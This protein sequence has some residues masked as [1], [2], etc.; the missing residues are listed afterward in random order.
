MLVTRTLNSHRSG[1]TPPTQLAET[2][3]PSA[4]QEPT[5]TVT[6][7]RSGSGEGWKMAGITTMLAAVPIG[8]VAKSA[9]VGAIVGLAGV[10]MMFGLDD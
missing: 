9:G 4:N 8:V 7:S 5:E 3:P 2:P 10:A 6:L 1:Y